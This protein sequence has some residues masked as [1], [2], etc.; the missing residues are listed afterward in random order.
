MSHAKPLNSYT[1]SG[2]P[3]IAMPAEGEISPIERLTNP[4]IQSQEV[5]SSEDN[6]VFNSVPDQAPQDESESYQDEPEQQ[7][8][9]LDYN[10]PQEIKSSPESDRSVKSKSSSEN[11]KELRLARERAEKKSRTTRSFDCSFIGTATSNAK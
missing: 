1:R 11:F 9:Q 4:N 6:V 8:E 3:N 5:Q 10:E 2:K 7:E